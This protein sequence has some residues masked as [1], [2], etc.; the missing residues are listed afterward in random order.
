MKSVTVSVCL[1]MYGIMFLSMNSIN[2]NTGTKKMKGAFPET[3]EIQYSDP[4]CDCLLDDYLFL[5]DIET[6]ESIYFMD[7]K[8]YLNMYYTLESEVPQSDEN[9]YGSAIYRVKEEFV[10]KAYGITYKRV[11]CPGYKSCNQGKI[12]KNIISSIK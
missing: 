7:D 12:Y 3:I 5:I 11:L 9:G 8:N 1:L 10:D 4:H 6:G 2:G